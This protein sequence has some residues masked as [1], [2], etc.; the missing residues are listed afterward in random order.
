MYNVHYHT[1]IRS[2]QAKY[3]LITVQSTK[4]FEIMKWA[5]VTRKTAE[6][7]FVN[8]FGN[9]NIGDISMIGYHSK[10]I[11]IQYK[12]SFSDWF[13]PYKTHTFENQNPLKFS[14]SV[15]TL[16]KCRLNVATRYLL[17]RKGK[18]EIILCM[19]TNA[20]SNT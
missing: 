18:D 1:Q 11:M 10:K 6:K 7:H 4:N 19:S 12:C 3:K 14:S 5:F 13:V 15:Y 20:N 2:N 8:F 9:G 17:K 16:S